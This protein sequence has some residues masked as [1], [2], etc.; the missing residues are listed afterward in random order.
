MNGRRQQERSR[1][2]PQARRRR[3]ARGLVWLAVA[4]LLSL[5]VMPVAGNAGAAGHQSHCT[6]GAHPH[7]PGHPAGPAGKPQQ[8]A[9]PFCAAHPGFSLPPPVLPGLAVVAV[10]RPAVAVAVADVIEP[11]HHFLSCLQSRA[12]PAVACPV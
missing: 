12:P 4:A 11:A 7:H 3:P 1:G 9:C 8:Q 6:A 5:L 10:P 2:A